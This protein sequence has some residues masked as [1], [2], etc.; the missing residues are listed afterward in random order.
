MSIRLHRI[1]LALL[2]GLSVAVVPAA[3][4]FA[5]GEPSP[6]MSASAAMPD[7]D[8]HPHAPGEKTQ[9]T[10]NDYACMAG[11]AQCF[12]FFTPPGVSGVTFSSSAVIAVK[13][14][15]A[16]DNLPSWTLGAP[17]RPPRS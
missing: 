9:K 3:G 4:G 11:C 17:F 8:H 16:A 15:C 2:V 12:S 14:I 7:C 5:M 6:E 10:A 13:P 1:I